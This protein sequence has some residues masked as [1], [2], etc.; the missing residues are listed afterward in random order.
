MQK[1]RLVGI[2]LMSALWLGAGL[3]RPAAAQDGEQTPEIPRLEWKWNAKEEKQLDKLEKK[4]KEDDKYFS[5]ESTDYIVRSDISARFS[6]ELCLYMDNFV[7]AFAKLFPMPPRGKVVSKLTV[8]VVSSREEYMKISGAPQWSGG[9]FVPDWG[10]RG[11]PQFNVYT[12]P[13]TDS[14]FSGTDFT[15]F[16]RG[17]LQHEGTHAMLTKFVGKS[18]FIIDGKPHDVLPVAINEGSA[19]YFENWNLRDD[20]KTNYAERHK[21]SFHLRD[22]KKYL[23][24]NASYQPKLDYLINLTHETWAPDNGGPET[25]RNYGLAESFVDFLLSDVK[26]RKIYKTIFE[27]I[28]KAQ[29]CLT[30]KEIA[31]LEPDWLEHMQKLFKDI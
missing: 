29:P 30:P 1:L 5:F 7:D 2:F 20:F 24:D 27:R 14:G 23:A 4:L 25:G 26:N 8:V 31:K 10:A 28:Y 21:R 17:V 19:C 22:L 11:W 16:N 15:F 12:F 3:D 13:W 6:A 9:V 18:V